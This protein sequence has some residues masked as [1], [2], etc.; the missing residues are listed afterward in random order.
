MLQSQK[1][2]GARC[3]RAGIP[4]LNISD[5]FIPG[6]LMV[7]L[8]QIYQ[9]FL[10]RVRFK[11]GGPNVSDIFGPDGLKYSTISGYGY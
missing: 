3:S 1:S 9:T 8:D 10:V 4:G 2:Q 11:S 6:C 5:V 7:R